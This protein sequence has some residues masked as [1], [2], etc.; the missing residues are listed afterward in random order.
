MKPC[1]CVEMMANEGKQR[2]ESAG[3]GQ[4]VQI[5]WSNLS[6]Q[7][8]SKGC[9]KVGCQ[10]PMIPYHFPGNIRDMNAP[11]NLM[12]IWCRGVIGGCSFVCFCCVQ[13]CKQNGW[14]KTPPEEQPICIS[15]SQVLDSYSL[16]HE[17]ELADFGPAKLSLCPKHCS[18]LL[19]FAV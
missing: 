14:I 7:A 10:G 19:A 5:D 16:P 6:T 2:H 3:N 17:N 4:R 11:H 13:P 9:Y 18:T 15:V 8:S 1:F 12:C